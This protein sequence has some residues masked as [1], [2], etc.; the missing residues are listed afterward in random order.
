MPQLRN[1]A[2]PFFI[3]FRMTSNCFDEILNCINEDIRK[4]TTHF[5]VPILRCTITM[6]RYV[7]DKYIN[8]MSWEFTTDYRRGKRKI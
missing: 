1:D 8:N 2:K 7:F 6:N 4:E 3:Y 5:R